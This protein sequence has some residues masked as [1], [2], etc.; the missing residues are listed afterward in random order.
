[1]SSENGVISGPIFLALKKAGFKAVAPATA[2]LT[3]P[4]NFEVFL[5]L[6]YGSKN[7][8]PEACAAQQNLHDENERN[9]VR[10]QS[11]SLTL[12][13]QK[14]L[15]GTFYFQKDAPYFSHAL[16]T[17]TINKYFLF[18]KGFSCIPI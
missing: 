3:P 11:R 6:R 4:L 16:Y 10:Q 18:S 8:R 7:G 2:K 15:T 5:I 14:Q 13:I 1:V 9:Q 17:E 12:S